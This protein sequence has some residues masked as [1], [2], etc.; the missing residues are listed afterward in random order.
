M[1]KF[2]ATLAVAPLA[3]GLAACSSSQTSGAS[4]DKTVKIG[5]VGEDPVNDKLK[6]AAAEKGI[7]VEY[8][9]MT[10]YNQPNPALKSGDTD[11][12]WF[13][14]IAYLADYNVNAGDNLNIVGPTV[15]YPMALFSKNHKSLGEIPQGGNIAIP[16]DT[17]NEARALLLLEANNLVKFKKDVKQPTVDDVDTAKSKVKIT[18]VNAQQT[19]TSMEST[20]GA[21]INNDFLKD[22]GLNPKDALAQDDP[23]NEYAKPYV[24][25]FVS[26]DENKDNETYKEVVD[27]FHSPE[28]QEV[29]KQETAG[30]AVEVKT[31]VKELRDTL[32]KTEDEARNK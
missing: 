15:I 22:A 10:D 8:S 25:L 6:E 12:N 3:L 4:D 29:V 7:N 28:V 32:K 5:I 18:P 23:S 27:I 26:T 14:H 1:K 2:L 17:V 30:T 21:V 9:V 19:V 11:M 24:N 13:Q 16:D 31:D 20:D